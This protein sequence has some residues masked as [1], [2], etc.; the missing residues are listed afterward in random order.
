MSG[1]WMMT[2]TIESSAES[3][4]LPLLPNRG[5][6]RTNSASWGSRIYSEEAESIQ[7]QPN[8]FRRS[9]ILNTGSLDLGNWK[10][11][12][13]S[14][15]LEDFQVFPHHRESNDQMC[16]FRLP[17]KPNWV[18]I[19]N[20]YLPRSIQVICSLRPMVGGGD[21]VVCTLLWFAWIKTI[22]CCDSINEDAS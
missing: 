19:R 5:V 6:Y 13:L 15:V 17:G 3:C 21:P 1:Y 22:R 20:L 18:R 4:R 9:R 14:R 11:G 7:K 8:L 12:E 10:C 2:Q 16:Q